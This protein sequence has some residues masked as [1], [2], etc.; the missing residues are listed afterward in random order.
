MT[1]LEQIFWRREALRILSREAA[2]GEMESKLLVQASEPE[3]A[4]RKRLVG[5]VRGLVEHDRYL[6]SRGAI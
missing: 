3:E 4:K 1:H 6:A 5:K 2:M